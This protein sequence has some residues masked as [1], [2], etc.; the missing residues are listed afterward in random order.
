[1]TKRCCR[2]ACAC[3]EECY[4]SYNRVGLARRPQIRV[5][6]L[7]EYKD[8]VED[9]PEDEEVPDNIPPRNVTVAIY[10]NNQYAFHQ[11]ISVASN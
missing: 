5:A 8:A 1:M 6:S 9:S 11:S 10:V 7:H 2:Q 3:V 4:R